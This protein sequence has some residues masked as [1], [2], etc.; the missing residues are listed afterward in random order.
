MDFI[1][2][3]SL[4]LYLPL[5]R[6]DGASFT[7]K[8]AYGHLCTVTGALWRSNGRY[9]D[10]VDDRID[11]GSS[12]LLRMTTDTTISAWARTSDLTANRGVISKSNIAVEDRLALVFTSTPYFVVF[13][14]SSDDGG[15]NLYGG[16]PV[17]DSWYFW[18]VRIGS[19]GFDL[20]INGTLIDSNADTN[21]LRDGT[22][23]NLYLGL[24]HN[25]TN[26]LSGM[27]GEVWIYNRALSP[28]E[29][30]RNYLATRG[31]YQ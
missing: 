8:D 19:Q 15:I 2:D 12:P 28:I 29:I 10:N 11:C 17:V 22:H 27:I 7:S 20:R 25:N 6:L 30:Q 4:V 26:P 24:D 16:T 14:E 9:F 5:Y 21:V 3:S 23:K 1:F 18:A 31:R 13:K